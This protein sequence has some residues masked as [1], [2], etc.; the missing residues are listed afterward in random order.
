MWLAG[1]FFDEST[2]EYEEVVYS[3]AG[4][5]SHGRP[6]LMVDLR[7]K[8]ALKE[9][10]LEYFKASEIE[11]GFGQF[12]QYRDDPNDIAKPL[13]QREKDLRTEIK[14]AFIDIICDEPD[15][16]GIGAGILVRDLRA[17]REDH[18]EL[19]RVLPSPYVM[20]ADLMLVQAGL[21]MNITNKNHPADPGLLRPIFDSH[22]V[23]EPPFIGGFDSFKRSNPISSV[24]LL[25]PIFESDRNY[26][27]LQAADCLAF[28]LRKF[29]YNKTFDPTRGTRKAMERLMECNIEVL[30][31]V[32]YNALLTVTR[33]Q[34]DPDAVLGRQIFT[35]RPTRSRKLAV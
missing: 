2:D 9:Y 5:V 1:G 32:D 7:W 27:C 16:V 25:E 8:A 3:V 18:P 6:S 30:F 15:F 35:G 20:C 24:S 22:E 11:H 17:F 21:M 31:H 23:Y 29:I 33:G 34:K 4:F 19:A 13:S 10:N 12:R 28:E 26:R 14:T